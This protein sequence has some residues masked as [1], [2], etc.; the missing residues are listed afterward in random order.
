MC[1][2]NEK[3]ACHLQSL[4]CTRTPSFYVIIIIMV[5][6][7]KKQQNKAK[8]KR[9]CYVLT[10]IVII[11]KIIKTK[12]FIYFIISSNTGSAA[13]MLITCLIFVLIIQIYLISLHC[14]IIVWRVQ[15]NCSASVHARW[16]DL[17]H[18]MWTLN[19]RHIYGQKNQK[20]FNNLSV[21]DGP[22][23]IIV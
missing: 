22:I 19:T 16:R 11:I 13:V 17:V 14:S 2:G 15:V 7:K 20:K 5:K 21:R 18:S 1:A 9:N 8:R 12:L 3:N 23:N 10:I 6:E 4:Y